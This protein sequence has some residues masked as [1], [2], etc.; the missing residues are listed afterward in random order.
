VISDC[1]TTSDCLFRTADPHHAR[2]GA[3]CV[4]IITQIATR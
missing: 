4:A 2:P 1:T 3:I